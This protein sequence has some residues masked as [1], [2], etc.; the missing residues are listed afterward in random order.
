MTA[1]SA[2]ETT[3]AVRHWL[4]ANASAI[5]ATEADHTGPDLDPLID[6]LA[7]A[8]VVGLGESTRF[9]RQTYG[10][11]ERILRALVLRHGFRALAIQDSARSGD[12]FDAYVRGG[13][14]TPEDVLAQAWR[15]LRTAE[16]IATMA[17]LRA[18]N[19]EHPHDPV[20]IFGVRPPDAESADYD[21]VLDHLRVAA[22]ELAPAVEAHLTPIRTAHRMDE[23]V[24]RH[25]RVHPGRPFA[26]HARDAYALLDGLP[27][28][29]A[30]DAALDH[31]RVIVEFHENS[32]AG[33]GG[34]AG[35]ELRS[36]RR[37]LERAAASRIVY[38]DGI[39]H[40]S[41]IPVGVGRTD[42]DAFVSTGSHLRTRLRAEYVAVALGFH[43]G[44]LGT[45]RAPGP[46]PDLLDAELGQV[47]LDAY[48]I[49]PHAEAPDEVARRWREPATMRVISGIYDESKD[50]EANMTVD[51]LLDA[52]D[53]LVHIRETSPVAWLPE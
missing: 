47:D 19:I 49:D 16:T 36:A 10:V 33:R 24:Q 14:G 32:V 35:D 9:S 27:A 44:D 46:A 6:R 20:T 38:W 1:L 2:P 50:S 40:I 52:F 26:E 11:R 12:R 15:P 4:R 25:R 51:A 22:P 21:A 31:A 18:Y 5:T 3:A 13:T 48:F 28:S 42:P 23:H 29:P 7:A 34:F 37:I 45:G 8:T 30:R 53:V 41:A 43:H 17:W 39:A